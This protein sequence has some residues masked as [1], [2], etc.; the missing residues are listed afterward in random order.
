MLDS[1]VSTRLNLN[2]YFKDRYNERQKPNFINCAKKIKIVALP[3]RLPTSLVCL[4]EKL[5]A[6]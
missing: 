1:K 4:P 6:I 2:L 3:V 5:N